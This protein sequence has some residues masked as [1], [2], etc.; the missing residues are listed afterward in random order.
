MKTWTYKEGQANKTTETEGKGSV[1]HFRAGYDRAVQYSTVQ[2][3][4]T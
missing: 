1:G 3:T 4:Y 2:V